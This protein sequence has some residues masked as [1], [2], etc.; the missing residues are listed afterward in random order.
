MVHFCLVR[1]LGCCCSCRLCASLEAHSRARQS[2]RSAVLRMLSPIVS[3]GHSGNCI[4]PH[5]LEKL[6]SLC[7][8]CWA[9]WPRCCCPC[10]LRASLVARCRARHVTYQLRLAPLLVSPPHVSFSPCAFVPFVCPSSFFVLFLFC[11][12]SSPPVCASSLF[13]FPLPSSLH[14]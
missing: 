2:Y 1:W 9:L 6:L 12:R 13:H 14:F 7:A 10:R 11:L 4:L 8:I 3:R 5:Q